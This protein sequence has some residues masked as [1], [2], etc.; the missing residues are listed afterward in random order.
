M[1]TLSFDFNHPVLT[2]PSSP[3]EVAAFLSVPVHYVLREIREKKLRATKLS[4]K[5]IRIFPADLIQWIEAGANIPKDG[6]RA[7]IPAMAVAIRAGA[8]PE[9][10]TAS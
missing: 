8:A 7:N 2:K 6:T 4:E 10:A 9:E 5:M 1:S 3:R